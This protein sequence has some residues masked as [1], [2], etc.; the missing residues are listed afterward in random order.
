MLIPDNL[1]I[2]GVILDMDGVLWRDMQP[3]GDLPAI[4]SRI[5]DLDMSVILA[6]NNATRTVEQ[7]H[8]EVKAFWRQ[9]GTLAG[10]KCGA[11][12]GILSEKKVS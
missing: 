8:A 5:R 2:K 6:T 12:S 3:I 10:C 1:F 9:S 11:G 7:Y 4:F